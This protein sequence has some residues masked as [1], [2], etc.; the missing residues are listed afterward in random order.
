MTLT[1]IEEIKQGDKQRQLSPAEEKSWNV[2]R[3]FS[4]RKGF[5]YWWGNIEDDI[6]N[7]IFAELI[8]TLEG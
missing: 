5:D 4:G 7:E 1:E 8:E 3:F 6:K 2:L